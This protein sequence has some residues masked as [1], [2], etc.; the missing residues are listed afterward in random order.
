MLH[1][2]F[3]PHL[4]FENQHGIRL[5]VVNCDCHD[6]S[7][8]SIALGK[9][10]RQNRGS[11]RDRQAGLPPASSQAHEQQSQTFGS[12]D[13]PKNIAARAKPPGTAGELSSHIK[14]HRNHWHLPGTKTSSPKLLL[15][16]VADLK[17]S[18]GPAFPPTPSDVSLTGCPILA[19]AELYFWI[20]VSQLAL[21]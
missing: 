16:G 20:F 11:V 12:E 3:W 10:Q 2:D 7:A 14:P 19:V 21:A 18:S 8:H 1:R 4:L 5:A 13:G 9:N 15:Q 6:T 17:R